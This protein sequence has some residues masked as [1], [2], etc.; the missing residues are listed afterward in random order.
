[1]KKS[2]LVIV[3]LTLLFTNSLLAQVNLKATANSP[4]SIGMVIYSNDVETVW[5]AF[6]LANHSKNQGDTVQVF[7][8]AKGVE[9]DLLVNDNKDL[10]DQVDAFLEKGG[11]I[12]GCG[13][14]LKS[15]KNDEP[16]VC[17]FSSLADLYA[18][19]RKNK[20]VLTF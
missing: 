1:M 17:T 13:T 20:I 15:R 4:T 12:Q 18:L 6:R 5:N 14:C 2:I 16:Q 9:V 3:V 19:I 11:E 10:K 8:L 7:L